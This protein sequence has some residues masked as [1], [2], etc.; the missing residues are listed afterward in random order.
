[1]VDAGT[2][3]IPLLVVGNVA[4]IAVIA[5]W[6]PVVREQRTRWF[7]VHAAAMLA[8]IVGWALRRP[9]AVPL[10]ALWLVASTIWYVVGGRRAPSVSRRP[11]P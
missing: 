5:R 11:P 7:A 9:A 4:A 2:A 3:A 6:V 8:V 1:V 10:N